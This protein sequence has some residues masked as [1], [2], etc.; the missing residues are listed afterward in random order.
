MVRAIS[1]RDVN[2]D[3]LR[4]ISMVMIVTL[5]ALGKSAALDKVIPLSLNYYI[6]YFFE[7]IAYLGV[8]LFILITGYYS[9]ES[10]FSSKKILY[11]ILETFFYSVLIYFLLLCF[12]IIRFSVKDLVYVFFPVLT[13]H[14]WYISVYVLTYFLLPFLNFADRLKKSD[15]KKLLIILF[16]FFSIIPTFV[17]FV[18]TFDLNNGYS[19]L[20][21]GFLILISKYIRKYSAERVKRINTIRFVAILAMLLIPAS[22]YV[23]AAVSKLMTGRIVGA[24]LFFRYNSFLV[25]IASVLLFILF[26]EIRIDD[27]R[28]TKI[29]VS[30]APL[31]LG[32]YLIHTNIF[33]KDIIWNI[34]KFDKYID[35]WFVIFIIIAGVFAIF[36]LGCGVD[37]L[38]KLLFDVVFRTK[39]ITLIC[40]KIDRKISLFRGE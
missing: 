18:D 8:N 17:F 25:L 30:L 12:G 2:I 5:H 36:V 37:L 32:V 10:K 21:F 33:I 3:L 23:I 35:D 19:F 22:R 14:Y 9:Q 38:R 24:G 39:R 28:L 6:L 13:R 40:G 15:F 4:V 7:G 11:I 20:W 34:F 27:P 31:T 29:I 16:V 26:L 1:K